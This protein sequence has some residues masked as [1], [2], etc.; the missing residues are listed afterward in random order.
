MEPYYKL[1]PYA[2][3]SKTKQELLAIA[4]AADA[5]IDISY[6]SSSLGQQRCS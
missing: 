3:S 5:F 6:K 4:T 1:V 2:I